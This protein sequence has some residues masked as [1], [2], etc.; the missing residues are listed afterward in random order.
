MLIKNYCNCRLGECKVGDVVEIQGI[1]D[2]HLV[3]NLTDFKD[4]KDATV[5]CVSLQS[6]SGHGFTQNAPCRIVLCEVH[7]L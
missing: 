6:G 4:D 7:V 2:L 1:K 3:T 5:I